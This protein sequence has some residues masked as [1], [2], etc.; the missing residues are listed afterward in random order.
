[1]KKRL[2][3]FVLAICMITA[4]LPV[5]NAVKP[6]PYYMEYDFQNNANKNWE[7]YV[8]SEGA[9]YFNSNGV[10]RT[11]YY[12]NGNGT[13]VY[14]GYGKTEDAYKESQIGDWAAFKLDVVG[15]GNF[16][17]T[18]Y[19]YETVKNYFKLFDI[20]LIPAPQTELATDAEKREYIW[21]ALNGG[22]YPAVTSMTDN[23]SPHSFEVTL[24]EGVSEYLLVFR[25]A[26]AD[27][28]RIGFTKLVFSSA[29]KTV[30]LS[31]EMTVKDK[32][33]SVSGMLSDGRDLTD[34]VTVTYQSSDPTVA[35]I[36]SASGEITELKPG[37]TVITASYIFDGQGYTETYLY[38][39][40]APSAAMD[41]S[42]EDILYN[43]LNVS[44]SWNAEKVIAA[45][46]PDANTAKQNDIRGVTYE[47]SGN[48]EYRGVGSAE[49]FGSWTPD[50]NDMT[51]TFTA[52][53]TESSH[54]RV[55]FGTDSTGKVD[56]S[57]AALNIKIP[58][59]GRYS[60]EVEYYATYSQ[61]SADLYLI[62]IIKGVSDDVYNDVIDDF[63][64]DKYYI[65]SFNSRDDSFKDQ[66]PSYEI[67][68]AKLESFN[69][70]EAGEYVLVFRRGDTGSQ[71]R[72]KKLYFNGINDLDYIDVSI[73]D[74]EI[75]YNEEETITIDAFRLDDTKMDE[76]EYT[77]EYST[78]YNDRVTVKNG[79]VKGIG[80]GAETIT[81]T[82]ADTTSSRS[83]DIAVVANDNTGIVHE[84]T[85]LS[86]PSVLYVRGAERLEWNIKM[87][88]GNVLKFPFNENVE[89]TIQPEGLVTVDETGK[90]FANTDNLEGDVTLTAKAEFK[91][92]RIESSVTFKIVLDEGKTE[93]N[94]YTEDMRK[95]ALDNVQKYA[96]AKAMQKEATASAEHYLD[97][98]E[99]L[100][101][102]LPAEGIPRSRSVGLNYD[103]FG[104]C[105][106]W[107]GV[108]S[109]LA[110]G[111]GDDGEW[112]IDP[113]NYPWKIQCL[114]CKRRFPTNDFGLFYNRCVEK[115]GYFDTKLARELNAYYVSIGEKDALKNELYNDLT[116]VCEYG[117]LREG[118]KIEDWGVDDGQ[119]YIPLKPD[120][121]AYCANRFD[122]NHVC[123]LANPL[124]NATTAPDA[125][126]CIAENHCYIPAYVNCF[127]ETYR[128]AISSLADAYLYTDD[129]KY[130]NACAILLDRLADVYPTYDHMVYQGALFETSSGVTGH[131]HILGAYADCS[132]S[133]RYVKAA[134]AVFECLENLEVINFL[135]DKAENKWNGS[136]SY[137]GSAYDIWKN[138]EKNLI[139]P[140]WDYVQ[141]G[142]YDAN[143]G[144]DESLVAL[145]ALVLDKEPE[146]SERIKWLWKTSTN[147]GKSKPH[148]Q[149]LLDRYANGEGFWYNGGELATTLVDV[150]HREGLGD[151]VSPEYLLGWIG[152]LSELAEALSKCKNAEEYQLY[153]HPKFIA[154][155][156]AFRPLLVSHYYTAQNG[157]TRGTGGDN[158]HFDEEASITMFQKISEMGLPEETVKEVREC[159]ARMLYITS[160]YDVDSINY[161]IFANNPES[162]QDEIIDIVKDSVP[163]FDSEM[164][165]GYAFAILRD[166]ALYS[167]EKSDEGTNTQR[168]I[169]MTFNSNNGHTHR[170]TLNIGMDAY[171]LNIAPD[172]GYPT[173]SGYFPERW[174]WTSQALAHNTVSIDR[175]TQDR[176]N[177][178]HGYP[179]HF[180][181]SGKVQLMDVS[182][183]WAYAQA[184]NYRRTVVMVQVNDSVSYGVDFFRVTG[185]SVHTYSFHSQA[186]NAYPVGGIELS[187]QTEDGTPNTPY[188]GTYAANFGAPMDYP[189]GKDPNSPNEYTYK[190]V[191]PRGYT[192]LKDVRRDL[193]PEQKIAVEFDVEDW[194]KITDG[195]DDIVLRLTQLSDFTPSEVAIAKGPTPERAENK[196]VPR[197]IDNVMIH[198]EAEEGETLDSL[199]T[200]VLEPYKE[201]RRYIRDMN[202]CSVKVTKGTPATDDVAY[203]V[204]VE[205]ENG[206]VDYIVYATN[207]TVTYRVDDTFDFKGFVGVYTVQNGVNTYRYVHDGSVIGTVGEDIGSGSFVGEV[208]GYRNTISTENYIDVAFGELNMTDEEANAA[209]ANK[210]VFVDNDEVRNGTYKITSAKLLENGDIRLN[211]GLITQIRG[212]IDIQNPDEGYV[213][214]VRDGQ[215]ATVYTSFVDEGVPE[216][217]T[218]DNDMG[219]SAGS[220]VTI[221]VNAKSPITSQPPKT[222]TYVGT[223]LPRGASLDSQIGV[224]T[225]KPSASQ[226]GDNH[227]AITAVD[228]DG[229]EA[230][231]HFDIKV[232]GSTTSKPSTDNDSE[233]SADTP[234]GGG[235]GGGGGAAPAPDTDE[236]VGDDDE[237]LP[238]EEKVPSEGEADEVENGN[239][240]NIRFTDLTS[241]AW[242]TDAINELAKAGIIK[243]TS[244]TTF[245][246]ANNITRAD[247]AILL[248][249][250]FG[251]ESDNTENFADVSESDYFAR[252][253]AVARNCG[254]VGGIG[255]NKYAPRNT[256]TRQDMMVIAYRALSSTLVGEGLRALPLTDEVSYPDFDTVAEYAKEAVTF[257][258]S[259]GLVNGK[260]GR[261]APTDYT[262]R[263]EV[264]VLVKRILDYV[265]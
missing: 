80:D 260:N 241:H 13:Q 44:T 262:T 189:V 83:K 48:W 165:P 127:I 64:V 181:D 203:A 219:V 94:Y 129:A 124:D 7:T 179:L 231:L 146:S 109:A 238:L 177:N 1:M 58:K 85:W 194:K 46:Y 170:D 180:D 132:A 202:A 256:I 89:Y 221:D 118:E 164:M 96:W 82:V 90:V 125:N 215:T 81:V 246:P 17:A 101:D 257:L 138:W 115:Y 208:T 141:S 60:A 184:D 200:T 163:V 70:P 168:S 122:P 158:I 174:Q 66:T 121:T 25:R 10:N 2:L 8:Y 187:Y 220:S 159:L 69:V 211:T 11:F 6:S 198:R 143:Y 131:G 204:K 22:S 259:A 71:V 234:S 134:D 244:E 182:V 99:T 156:T 210:Y 23:V 193:S 205:H 42:G 84:E 57:Y 152:Q 264:A 77:V 223:T 137:K 3:S 160:G 255:D 97:I 237:S 167:K 183:P 104:H 254:I 26:H 151:E 32:K 111:D 161:G 33:A 108:D 123:N 142:R 18:L 253:L 252:E 27:R 218:V 87:R 145:T 53:T 5:T 92:E 31:S 209:F 130:G 251:L 88:S 107:C 250:A 201:G 214:N 40:D 175:E 149:K 113:V 186:Q 150:C 148:S 139:E 95:N 49:G 62:P 35:S 136:V 248:V 213:Y 54:M 45:G 86:F 16:N 20:Y 247:F 188:I 157:D 15:S 12:S 226:I 29:D 155:Y 225:W 114:N 63:C 126:S 147:H 100:Y 110:F 227:V 120:G 217:E 55:S 153:T 245:S 240:A 37:I 140:M 74:N 76:S 9:E 41:W 169:F 106:R 39:I 59:A 162:I 176:P 128:N 68:T 199:F 235:G 135:E 112:H 98:Y 19:N 263:A 185:G 4:L 230:T 28:N 216:F 133:L 154:M 47:Y 93:S 229:R 144:H 232:Y 72:L 178:V 36:D 43:F 228:N 116:G 242:A 38:E 258:I 206:R 171:G 75:C 166:G 190:T 191:Y 65:G 73:S 52:P 24:S 207:N 233:G 195:G 117:A 105:C 212:H 102:N 222:I 51:S 78:V 224:F 249:R 103:D 34:A 119:G 50:D 243:G 67:R 21:T 239:T 91:G 192:W 197:W 236:N 79:V 172:L 56:T 265:E 261:I 14:V 173:E 30:I 61:G 196:N